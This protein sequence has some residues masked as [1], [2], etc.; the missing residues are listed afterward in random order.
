ME[1][2]H[3]DMLKRRSLDPDLYEFVKE[4]YTSVYFRHIFTGKIKIVDKGARYN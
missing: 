4:T 3:K 1:R 2:K